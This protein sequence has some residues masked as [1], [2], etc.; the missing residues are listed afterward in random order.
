MSDSVVQV[1]DNALNSL[2]KK[3]GKCDVLSNRMNKITEKFAQKVKNAEELIL[4]GDELEETANT[5]LTDV[6]N[7]P[8]DDKEYHFD[9]NLLPQILNLENMMTDVRYIRETLKENSDIGR[10]LLKMLAE[11]LAFEPDAEMLA[12]YSQL[13][14][15]ITENMRLFLQCYR[16]I[17]HILLNIS[18]LTKQ[19]APNTIINNVTI[20]SESNTKIKNTAELIKQLSKL[21]T[22]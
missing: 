14:S 2:S 7:L 9:I 20:E 18:K 11:D 17:S 6:K 16:D 21:K 15:T 12:S 5:V 22:E 1:V 10:K 19:E 3:T 8:A 13:S 4:C